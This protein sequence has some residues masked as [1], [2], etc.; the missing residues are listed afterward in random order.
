MS[1]IKTAVNPERSE[2]KSKDP[3]EIAVSF[4]TGFLDFARNDSKGQAQTNSRSSA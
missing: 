2:A 1:V 4:A 3:M